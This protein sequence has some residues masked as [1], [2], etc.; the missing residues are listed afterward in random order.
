MRGQRGPQ[1]PL[2]SGRCSNSPKLALQ[3]QLSPAIDGGS[4]WSAWRR[5]KGDALLQPARAPAAKSSLHGAHRLDAGSCDLPAHVHLI[6]SMPGSL[7]DHCGAP[8]C[9]LRRLGTDFVPAPPLCSPPA[10]PR[11]M[12]R[13]T[14]Q[15]V[16]A[17][18]WYCR[19][20]KTGA[21][22]TRRKAAK[23]ARGGAL[24]VPDPTHPAAAHW[25]MHRSA[26]AVRQTRLWH[27]G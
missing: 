11:P 3:S 12:K 22:G 16:A 6:C 20:R 24:S 13:S 21:K 4:L 15:K 5:V 7:W 26:T 9:A 14:T 27:A 25:R 19:A 17:C 10:P 1:P 23:S 18:R 8:G 2:A